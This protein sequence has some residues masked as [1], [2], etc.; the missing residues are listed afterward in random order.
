MKRTLL[1]LLLPLLIAPL[2]RAEI[3]TRDAILADRA[4]RPLTLRFFY[5]TTAREGAAMIGDNPALT[6][7]RAIPGAPIVPGPVPLVIFSHGSGGNLTNQAWLAAALAER[8]MIAVSLNHPGTTTRDNGPPGSAALWERPADIRRVIDAVLQAGSAI[9][10][11]GGQVAPDRIALIG[12]SLGGFTALWS[13]GARFDL[14]RFEADCRTPASPAPC[15][16]AKLYHLG[17]TA[18]APAR[19]AAD[20]REPRLRAAVALDPGLARA[21]SPDSLTRVET[22]LLLIPATAPNPEMPPAAETGYLA[23]HLPPANHRVEPLAGA[24]HFSFLP[25]CKPGGA[26]L[27]AADDP[28]DA[29]ICRDGPGGNRADLHRRTIALVADFLEKSGF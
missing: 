10:P 15:R 29:I 19:L 11:P 6:G 13:L 8:G 21:F 9:L 28:D 23:A 12:H 14:A 16:I 18:E 7:V 1:A 24:A 25:E 2:A 17:K 20:Q 27:I 5:P 26:A 22:P 3:G 4:D